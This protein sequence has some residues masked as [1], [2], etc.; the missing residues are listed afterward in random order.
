MNTSSVA[1]TRLTWQYEPN[2]FPRL[3]G[4]DI[5]ISTIAADGCLYCFGDEYRAEEGTVVLIDA[6]PK[7]WNE[8]GRFALPEK[9][10]LRKPSGRVWTHPVIANG[11][12]YVRDQELIFCYD[13]RGDRAEN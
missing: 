9:S 6:S 7:E 13:L 11:R 5:L 4:L 3:A 8:K 2:G 1:F 10:K 12:L